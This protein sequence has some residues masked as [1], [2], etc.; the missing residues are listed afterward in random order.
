MQVHLGQASSATC[1]GALSTWFVIWLLSFLIDESTIRLAFDFTQP[2]VISRSGEEKHIFH[3]CVS[4]LHIFGTF[5]PPTIK[6]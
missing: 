2:A 3:L 1:R 4:R 5:A 6:H